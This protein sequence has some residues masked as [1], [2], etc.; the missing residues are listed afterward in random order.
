[1]KLQTAVSSKISTV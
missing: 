1:L